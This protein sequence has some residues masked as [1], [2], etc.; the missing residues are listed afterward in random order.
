MSQLKHTFKTDILFKML[1]VKYPELLKCLISHLLKIPL[2][3]IKQFEIQNPEMPP[4]SIESKFCRLDIHMKVNKQQTNLEVQVEDEGD[5][6]ERTLFHWARIY[7]NS[8]PK[9]NDYSKLP[10]AILINIINFS[11]FKDCTEFHSEFRALE[12][13]RNDQLTDKM[14]L[15]FFELPKLTDELNKDDLLKLWLLLFKANTEEELKQIDRLGVSEM[16][17]AIAAYNNITASP[18]FQEIERLHIKASHDE[19]QALRNAK[20]KGKAEGKRE[21][22]RKG[23]RKSSINIAKKLLNL[24]VPIDK[25]ITATGLTQEE[26]EELSVHNPA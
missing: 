7:S 23:E 13:T 22:E 12:I 1:F 24:D 4:E 15:H 25:I 17:E 26:I 8:L 18:E 9:G 6:P 3:K 10:R 16:S 21:G 19:A 2:N 5:Y 14:V 20:L 11:L